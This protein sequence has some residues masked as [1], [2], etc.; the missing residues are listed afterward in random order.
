MPR[1]SFEHRVD[2][3]LLRLVECGSLRRL[4][5]PHDG[6]YLVPIAA[7]E[8]AATLLSFGVSADWSFERAATALNPS[9]TVHAYDH[10]VRGRK[11]VKAGI[12][13]GAAVIWRSLGLNF[14]GARASIER[15]RR[16]IDYFR[17]FR[18]RVHHHRQRVWYNSDRGSAAIA[19]II[20]A[21]GPHADLSVFAKIDIEGSEYRVL[22]YIAAHAQAFAGLVI[23]FH[24]SDICA[25]ALNAQLTELRERFEV[26]HVHGNNYGDLSVDGALPLS[27]EVTLMNKSLFDESPIPYRG[28]LPRPGL[29]APNDSRKPDYT[30]DLY[31]AASSAG[32]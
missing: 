30:L 27:L 15:L 6:G 16:S 21:T 4:G 24:D 13:S 18:G 7:I 28:P 12:E 22:P 8:G 3:T 32:S 5:G 29:D 9:L 19:D 10:T 14:R 11:F 31:R 1:A 17:F 20:A 25:D 2:P 26:V 23:E